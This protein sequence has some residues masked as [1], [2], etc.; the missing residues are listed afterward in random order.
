M[1]A[2][3][4]RAHCVDDAIELADVDGEIAR[5]RARDEIRSPLASPVSRRLLMKIDPVEG[6]DARMTR[7]ERIGGIG[8]MLLGI[9]SFASMDA[10]GKW[11]VRDVS[12][13]QILAVRNIS[14][15]RALF[16]ERPSRSSHLSSTARSFGPPFWGSSSSASSR[17]PTYGSASPSSWPRVSTRSSVKRRKA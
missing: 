2:S 7:H 6:S 8:Y 14:G 17:A 1:I 15:S 5:G 3:P 11:L 4:S 16:K 13:F 9:A 12:V 10:I